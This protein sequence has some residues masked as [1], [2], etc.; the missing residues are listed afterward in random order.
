M[1]D[2]KHETVTSS[3]YH[4]QTND[5]VEIVNH[6][7]RQMLA[8]LVADGQNNWDDML[9]H[10]VA[11]DNNSAS[12]GIGLAPNEVHNIGIYPQIMPMKILEE[13]GAK[14]LKVCK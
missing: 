13:I 7:L 5:M 14:H 3:F 4:L 11:A 9:M 6:A 12:R 1:D 8:Y 10:A 2:G